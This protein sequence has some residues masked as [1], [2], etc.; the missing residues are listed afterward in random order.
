MKSKQYRQKGKGILGKTENAYTVNR[1][2]IR[3]K[4]CP[5]LQSF[6]KITITNDPYKPLVI[7]IGGEGEI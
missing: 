3:S 7:V 4:I 5:V 2:S 1:A 6:P